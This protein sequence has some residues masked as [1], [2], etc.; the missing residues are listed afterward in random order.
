MTTKLISDIKIGDRHRK[1]MGDIPALAASI[2]EIGLINPITIDENGHLL[3][4][5]R[6]LAACKQLGLE[7]IE[8]RIM[9]CNNGR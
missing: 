7:T 6:R 4:G 5:A 9:S 1:D 2:R 3:A 8:V